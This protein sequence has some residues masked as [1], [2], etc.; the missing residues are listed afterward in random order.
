MCVCVCWHVRLSVHTSSVCVPVPGPAFRTRSTLGS[1]LCGR[2]DGT[3][4]HNIGIEFGR[5]GICH[6]PEGEHIRTHMR[7]HTLATNAQSVSL[8]QG[9]YRADSACSTSLRRFKSPYTPCPQRQRRQQ[10]QLTDNAHYSRHKGAAYCTLTHIRSRTLCNCMCVFFCCILRT[11]PNGTGGYLMLPSSVS[12]VSKTFGTLSRRAH[13]I[14]HMY[15][16]VCVCVCVRVD[17]A[18]ATSCVSSSSSST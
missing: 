18:R 17:R 10:Q 1:A 9:P 11:R 13:R 6:K 7:T 8:F 14:P 12:N 5:C 16:L 2:R 3:I 15:V 4:G